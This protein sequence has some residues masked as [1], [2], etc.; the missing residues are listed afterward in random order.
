[1]ASSIDPDDDIEIETEEQHESLRILDDQHSI[2]KYY[3]CE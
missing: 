2:A 3:P 1:M